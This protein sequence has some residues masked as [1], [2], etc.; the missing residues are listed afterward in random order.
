LGSATRQPV[1][2]TEGPPGGVPNVVRHSTHTRFAGSGTVAPHDG[3]V[4]TAGAW[5]VSWRAS[6]TSGFP[7][8]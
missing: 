8:I 5:V 2:A 1:N 3:Q 6:T 4:S 7:Q